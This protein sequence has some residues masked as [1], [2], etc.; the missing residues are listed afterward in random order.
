MD[1]GGFSVLALSVV[2]NVVIK[3]SFELLL[4]NFQAHLSLC[5]FVFFNYCVCVFFRI[6]ILSAIFLYFL[7]LNKELKLKSNY[8]API[9][10]TILRLSYSKYVCSLHPH[11]IRT[12]SIIGKKMEKFPR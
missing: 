12:F 6:L 11:F 8:A 2:K 7:R 1:L 3:C 4:T 9:H 5:I 10:F